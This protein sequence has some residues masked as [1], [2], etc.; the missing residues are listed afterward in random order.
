MK[1]YVFY[2]V[3]FLLSCAIL[4]CTKE[5]NHPNC[6]LVPVVGPCKANIPKYYFDKTDQKC[7]EFIWG[8]CNGVVPF[9]TQI[10]CNKKCTCQ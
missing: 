10:E 8:G 1:S 3:I 2:F 9:E 4:S 5:E 7:K 6:S